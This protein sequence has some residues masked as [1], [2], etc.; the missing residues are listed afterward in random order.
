MSDTQMPPAN[1][2]SVHM[3]GDGIPLDPKEFSAL[4]ARLT[5]DGN[6]AVD[7]YST[8]GVVSDFE[9]EAADLLGKEDAVILPTGTMANTLALEALAGRGG[10][11]IVPFESHLYRDSGDAAQ[12]LAG[13][14][15]IPVPGAFPGEEDIRSIVGRSQDEKVG[16]P[17]KAMLVESPVRRLHES[18]FPLEQYSCAIAAGKQAGLRLHLDGARLFVWSVWCE[19]SPAELA[20]GFETVYVSLYKYFNSLFGAVL[21]GPRGVI[22]DVRRWRRRNGGGLPQIWPVALIARH[23]M[24]GFLDRLANARRASQIV[25]EGLKSIPGVS[26]RRPENATSAALFSWDHAGLE[27]AR[28]LK[29]ELAR[30]RIHLPDY[31]EASDGFWIKVNETWNS[32]DPEAIVQGFRASLASMNELGM[33]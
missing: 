9:K 29:K 4:L 33:T 23:F 18:A 15:L 14:N 27:N 22:G 2:S 20:A 31:N 16:V 17:V 12:C 5:R 7:D 28:V 19:K 26:V 8:G 30:H 24:P 13:L 21:A 6:V 3:A 10:R 25:F 1:L 32:L 11:V